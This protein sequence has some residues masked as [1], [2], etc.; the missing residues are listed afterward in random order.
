MLLQESFHGVERVVLTSITTS[1]RF[2]SRS[3]FPL[4]RSALLNG[5]ELSSKRIKL[6]LTLITPSRQFIVGIRSS[7]FSGRGTPL[8]LIQLK[9]AGPI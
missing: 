6:R 5:L 3:F 8:I 2:L 9:L 4:Q 1:R 7:A